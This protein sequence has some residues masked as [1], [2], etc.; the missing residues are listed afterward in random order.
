M[1]FETR[2][3]W[4]FNEIYIFHVNN[5]PRLNSRHW[6]ISIWI[7][8]HKSIESQIDIYYQW[9]QTA[10]VDYYMQKFKWEIQNLFA[11]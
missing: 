6:F 9:I 1:P 2:A 5:L 3:Q 10:I 4:A 7:T 11:S 8:N